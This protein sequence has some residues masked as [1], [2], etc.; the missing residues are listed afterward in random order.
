M[1]MAGTGSVGD[2]LLRESRIPVVIHRGTHAELGNG[3]SREHTHVRQRCERN[4]GQL[5]THIFLKHK[6]P[7]TLKILSF[8]S[9]ATC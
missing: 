5:G 8:A 6:S 1:G 7:K 3:T 9:F 4:N 2:C